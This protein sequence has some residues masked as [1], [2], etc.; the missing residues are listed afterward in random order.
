MGFLAREDRLQVLISTQRK[1]FGKSLDIVGV[2]DS[3]DPPIHAHRQRRRD[4][5]RILPEV[6][7]PSAQRIT[8]IRASRISQREPPL[9]PPAAD[10]VASAAIRR[11]RPN[12]L[13]IP[14]VL[15]PCLHAGRRRRRCRP[16]WSHPWSTGPAGRASRPTTAPAPTRGRREGA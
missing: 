4:L 1:I 13:F 6:R 14:A 3:P 5:S 8:A 12:S 9:R 11:R 2:T 10:S 16:W 7:H 15:P